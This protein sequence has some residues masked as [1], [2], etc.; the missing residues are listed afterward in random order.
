M[1]EPTRGRVVLFHHEGANPG[2]LPH[3]ALVIDVQ[4]ERSVSLA[5]FSPEGT[6]YS[7]P[8]VQLLQDDDA[9]PPEG[10]GFAEWMAFQKGQ[11]V[12]TEAVAGDVHPRLAKLEE[13]LT[14]GGP[15]HTLVQDLQTG[16]G[17]KI[18]EVQTGVDSKFAELGD[19]LAKKFAAM[20]HPLEQPAPQPPA[21][22]PNPPIAPEAAA[23]GTA[24]GGPAPQA[25]ADISGAGA[26]PQ[27]QA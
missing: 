5:C 3:T 7:R 22:P 16:I 8:A 4:S 18:G 15:I 25:A 13:L 23:D 9:A 1:I 6:Y 14:A 17:E 12:K 19:F 21:N 27:P 11:A 20:G 24:Q 2:D 10:T 26:A